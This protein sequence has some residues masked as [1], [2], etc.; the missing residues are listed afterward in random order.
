MV[1]I[2]QLLLLV[3]LYYD[4]MF[5]W[6]ALRELPPKL[7]DTTEVDGKLVGLLV[8]AKQ[9]IEK[10]NIVENL[11]GFADRFITLQNLESFS[12]SLP[13]DYP[14][15]NSSTLGLYQHSIDHQYQELFQHL[16][17]Y[18]NKSPK[19]LR[20]YDGLVSRFRRG[21]GIINPCG[22]NVRFL[23]KH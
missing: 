16:F 19:L 20:S 12:N 3:I 21:R 9:A 4:V 5:L 6:E 13:A 8:K 1:C 18:L 23:F 17:P 22:R 7:Y 11:G 10:E 2:L 14:L 15:L